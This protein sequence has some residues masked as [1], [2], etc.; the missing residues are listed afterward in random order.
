MFF[1]LPP[2]P[3]LTVDHE[4]PGE[5][6]FE[7]AGMTFDVR[8]T[9]GHSPGSVTL[10]SHDARLA[11]VGDVVFAGSVGRTDLPGC[12]HQ[13]LMDSIERVILPLPDDYLLLSGHGPRTTVGNERETNPYLRG[14][15]ARV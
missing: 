4:L 8:H 5:G 7:V 12:N 13:A 6:T 1:G 10:I 2:G 11:I 3:V 14:L 15:K 9:P